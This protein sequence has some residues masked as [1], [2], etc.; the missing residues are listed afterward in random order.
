VGGV[1]AG[2]ELYILFHNYDISGGEEILP[3]RRLFDDRGRAAVVS[4]GRNVHG[5]ESFA[6]TDSAHETCHSTRSEG[7]RSQRLRGV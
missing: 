7:V 1:H 3:T 2:G 5:E 6:S 4:A